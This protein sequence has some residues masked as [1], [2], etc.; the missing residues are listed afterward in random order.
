MIDLCFERG[1]K[2]N[3]NLDIGAP[4][5]ES[6]INSADESLGSNLQTDKYSPFPA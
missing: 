5:S 6:N 4:V 2:S 1:I 3:K